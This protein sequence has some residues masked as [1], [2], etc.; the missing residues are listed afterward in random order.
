L[1]TPSLGCEVT[2]DWSDIEAAGSQLHRRIP[3]G[4]LVE[5][6]PR[7]GVERIITFLGRFAHAFTAKYAKGQIEHKND[8]L[9]LPIKTL[10]GHATEEV[11]DQWSYV[12][13]CNIRIAEAIMWINKAIEIADVPGEDRDVLMPLFEAINVLDGS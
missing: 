6:L 10:L 2:E 13:G 4:H 7:F 11:L 12:D 5:G 8:L 9:T 1:A 3:L